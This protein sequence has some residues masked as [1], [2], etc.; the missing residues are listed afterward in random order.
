MK[1]EEIIINEV[2][3]GTPAVRARLRNTPVVS[4]K[5]F[6]GLAEPCD[7]VVTQTPGYNLKTNSL[8]VI[9]KVMR[10]AQGSPY[11]SSK[12]VLPNGNLIGYGVDADQDN[13]YL[14]QLPLKEYIR[15]CEF[16][17]L[18]RVPTITENQKQKIYKYLLTRQ[19]VPYNKI[20]LLKTAW[21][22]IMPDFLGVDFKIDEPE[23]KR[24]IRGYRKALFCS[25][26]ISMAFL[27]V[28]VVLFEKPLEAWPRNF[29]L[30]P[31]AILIA[32]IVG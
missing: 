5:T 7:I 19:S 2:F 8:K 22:K 10:F 27:Y 1:K 32:R 15:R 30:T 25:T 14:S 28:G 21:N 17:C 6:F 24:I 13:T 12:L 9:S 3:Q 31:K 26:I 16:A 23:D 4:K 11:T 29:I 18:I 20:G